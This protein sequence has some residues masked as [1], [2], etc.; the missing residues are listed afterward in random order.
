MKKL[1][2]IALCVALVG[3]GAIACKKPV[4]TPPDEDTTTIET[5]EEVIDSAAMDSMPAEDAPEAPE[6]TTQ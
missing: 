2:A 6:E 1:L 5:P 4:E 3:F